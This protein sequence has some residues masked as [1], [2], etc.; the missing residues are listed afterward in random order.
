MTYL[1]HYFKDSPMYETKFVS[2]INFLKSRA[3]A[4]YGGA[5]L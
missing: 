1:H 3:G 4:K 5:Q 2:H